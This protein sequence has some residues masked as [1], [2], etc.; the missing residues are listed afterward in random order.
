MYFVP[1][2]DTSPPPPF[3]AVLLAG[4]KSTRMGRD[5]AGVQF[6]GQPLWQRQLATLR[7]VHPHEL[8]ISGKSDG[9]YANAGVEILAD[10]FPGL[11]PLAGL[12]A[13]LR[14]A[15][16]P[17]VLILAID[18]PA[19]TAGFLIELVRLAAEGGIG[20]VP[21]HDRWFEPLA[22]V[23]PR[24]CLALAEAGLRDADRSMQHFVSLA[25]AAD[26][27]RGRV[28][29]E[30]ERPLFQNTNLPGDL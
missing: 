9:P 29:A 22:A 3:T 14:R 1:F 7:A 21:H 13:A 27:I 28:V 17:L 2:V 12:E 20:C 5:K 16:H 8:F 30:T 11:G 4:G 15:R 23:Y 6:D 26:L 25:A 24:T 19:M 10:N 18:L